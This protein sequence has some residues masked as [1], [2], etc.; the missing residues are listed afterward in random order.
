MRWN[1]L[2]AVKQML[3]DTARVP[4]TYITLSH[5]PRGGREQQV[6]SRPYEDWQ[7]VLGWLDRTAR[8]LDPSPEGVK[9]RTRVFKKGGKPLKSVVS[10]LTGRGKGPKVAERG[11]TAPA[12][13]TTTTGVQPQPAPGMCP[14]CVATQALLATKQLQVVDLE[15]R[16]DHARRKALTLEERLVGAK[17]ELKEAGRI[18]A[19]LQERVAEL[20]HDQARATRILERYIAARGDAA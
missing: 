18:I 12:A 5:L 16:F 20:E 13:S 4:D 19:A 15:A 11:G 7:D 1:N 3:R 2:D 6:G 8:S 17:A 14:A 9:V 10:R